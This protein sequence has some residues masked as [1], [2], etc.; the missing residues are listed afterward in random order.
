[1]NPSSTSPS[2]GRKS[3]SASSIKWSS[4]PSGVLEIRDIETA[5]RPDYSPQIPA[6]THAHWCWQK[7]LESPSEASAL[8][9][10]EHYRNR[11]KAAPAPAGW[12]SA[13]E[14]FR[15]RLVS[16][17]PSIRSGVLKVMLEL[18]GNWEKTG[19]ERFLQGLNFNRLPSLKSPRGEYLP[20][21]TALIRSTKTTR[22]AVTNSPRF[23]PSPEEMTAG[24]MDFEGMCEVLWSSTRATHFECWRK[25]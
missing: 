11:I 10:L 25:R 16:S 24:R 21:R 6:G 1:M 22:A 7:F 14:D 5:L 15:L 2:I 13:V 19:D 8:A 18:L 12:Q 17:R 20:S 3:H 23:R 9:T 4:E